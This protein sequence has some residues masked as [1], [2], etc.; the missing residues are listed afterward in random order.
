MLVGVIA[1]G[2]VDV[3]GET[4]G[5]I[6]IK[7]FKINIGKKQ[8]TSMK[9]TFQTVIVVGVFA[10]FVGFI[11]VLILGYSILLNSKYTLINVGSN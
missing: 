2:M 9:V 1:S 4:L 11:T 5:V 8:P 3:F 6:R 10:S 7:K